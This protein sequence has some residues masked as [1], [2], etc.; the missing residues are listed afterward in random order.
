MKCTKPCSRNEV[1]VL[2][3]LVLDHLSHLVLTDLCGGNESEPLINWSLM[4][5]GGSPGG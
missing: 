3:S 5:G 4:S 2:S 1:V